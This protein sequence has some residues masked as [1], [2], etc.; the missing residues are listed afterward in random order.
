MKLYD[1]AFFVEK[2]LEQA[3]GSFACCA[4]GYGLKDERTI[5]RLT[6]LQDCIEAYDQ[7]SAEIRLGRQA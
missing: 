5:D 4:V 1:Q 7:I 6:S 2:R 3:E